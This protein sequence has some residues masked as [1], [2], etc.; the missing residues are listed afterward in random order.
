MYRFLVLTLDPLA[1]QEKS[2]QI[3]NESAKPETTY[4]SLS[5]IRLEPPGN[6]K[7]Q[8]L[9][10]YKRQFQ[11]KELREKQWRTAYEVC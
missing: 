11:L 3:I 4:L 10:Y 7:T 6:K 2:E 9:P 1:I 8:S 5:E